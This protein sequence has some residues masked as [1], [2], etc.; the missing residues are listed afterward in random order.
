M[1]TQVMDQLLAANPIEVP[2][3]LVGQEI[4]RMRDEASQRFGRQIKPEQKAQLF[5]DEMLK[6]GARR[7]VALG[8]ILSEI[9]KQHQLKPDEARVETMLDDLA[10]S[11]EQKD[12]FKQ[13]Y[14]GRPDL[15]QGLRSLALEDQVIEKLLAQARQVEKKL[16][17]DELLN[18]RQ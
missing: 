7:R 17:V 8:L 3:A 16:S 11:Y 6:D 2:E 14:R 5:P 12:Q 4:E 18:N 9:I 10:S 1:K 13:M 15:M